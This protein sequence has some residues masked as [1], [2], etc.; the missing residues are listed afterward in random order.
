M[1][2]KKKKV[3]TKKIATK[4]K[5]RVTIGSLQ[6][7]VLDLEKEVAYCTNKTIDIAKNLSNV[8][9]D[10]TLIQGWID[11][12]KKTSLKH[13]LWLVGVSVSTIIALILCM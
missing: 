13:T 2:T 7:R 5:A 12:H 10:L 4:T 8:Q 11:N 3:A 9:G 1:A 6:K